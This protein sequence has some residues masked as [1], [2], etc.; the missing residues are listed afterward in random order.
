MARV[1]SSLEISLDSIID[2]ENDV[3]T[4]KE[5]ERD[6]QKTD[7]FVDKVTG[8]YVRH[9]W[10][11]VALEDIMDLCNEKR[12]ECDKLPTKKQQIMK[13]FRQ[14]R[15]L[16]EIFY[17]VDCEK[18]NCATKV[19]SENSNN[20]K[21]CRCD[22]V[23]KTKETNFFVSF[24]IAPQ[25][26]KSLK[27]NWSYISTFD[28]SS[29]PMAFTDVHD[30]EILRNVLEQYRETDVNIVSL[31]LNIDGANKFKSNALSVWPIQLVQNNLPPRI[32]FLPENIIISGLYYNNGKPDCQKYLLPLVS[33]LSE[34]KEN[35]IKITIENEDFTFKPLIT[36]AVVD[37][38]AKSILQET[39]QFG[40]YD[41]CTYCE[42]PGELVEIKRD[43]KKK[44]AISKDK[45]TTETSKFVRYL[46]GDEDFKLRDEVDT[47]EK[48]LQ[49]HTSSDGKAID[50]I[51]G[52]SCLVGL[53]HF[54]IIFGMGIDYMHC[55]LLGSVKRLMDFCCNPKFSH[56]LFYI[57]PKIRK[58]L[59]EKILAIKPTSSIVRKPRSLDQRKNFKASEFRSL[60]LY[61]LPVCLPGCLPN[62]Y[63][64][65]IRMLSAA[66]YM[67]LKE[68]IPRIEVDQAGEM[69]N[70][71]VKQHQD[72]Y[73]KEN[74]VT[75]IHLLKHI[76]VAV[77]KQGP[78]WA[79]SAFPFERN[80]GCILKM[81]N[82]TT[83]V[84]Y[85]M[86][87]KYVLKNSLTN[88]PDDTKKAVRKNDNFL[89]KSITIAEH[90]LFAL[91]V[92]NLQRLNLSNVPLE[93]YKRCQLGKSIFTSILYTRPKRSVDYFVKLFGGQIG[94]VKFYWKMG[95]ENFVFVE[96]YEVI[97]NIYHI[98]KVQSTKKVIMAPIE[99]ITEKKIFMQV[100]LY[101]YVVSPPNHYENE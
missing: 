26:L 87:T 73:G 23:L 36:L 66:V 37:L 65:H 24:P 3:T 2:S 84:L 57:A 94:A 39:K 16:L 10:S 69:L 70:D 55:V 1:N 100:G 83:D 78:L 49:V 97:D 31:S 71:F 76:T 11:L 92:V 90:G 80:N 53:E 91:N 27:D 40:S 46:E 95:E 44:K 8:R 56:R 82:G 52:V 86:S 74:M 25:I 85:Q 75:V 79:Q 5:D 9:N 64:Q 34:L 6:I 93:V 29:N 67:L 15:D 18:C 19:N 63:V 54:N 13:L 30:G 61:Y 38:P 99:F 14:N 43:K 68:N 101:K 35:N 81:I 59:N 89:G 42:N 58:T 20:V 51:K 62:R 21:C 4:N 88:R 72:L 22:T 28:T 50:G 32:R 33:E 98:E 48:M 7:P 47:L 12:E 77:E 41:G 60:L 96:E 17:Y 45:I